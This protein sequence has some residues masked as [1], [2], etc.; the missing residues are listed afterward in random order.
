MKVSAEDVESGFY[1]FYPIVKYK[2][3]NKNIFIGYFI[4]MQESIKNI[5]SE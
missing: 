4:K 2:E 5:F 3:D 1:D